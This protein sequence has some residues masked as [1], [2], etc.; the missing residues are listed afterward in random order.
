MHQIPPVAAPIAILTFAAM[1][2]VGRPGLL[3][4][5]AGRLLGRRQL[6]RRLSPQIPQPSLRRPQSGLVQWMDCKPRR[7]R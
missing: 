6:L 5:A 1:I 4:G 3:S 7:R 2:L